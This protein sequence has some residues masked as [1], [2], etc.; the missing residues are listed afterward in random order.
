MRITITVEDPTPEIATFLLALASQPTATVTTEPDDRWTPERA[1]AY[2]NLLPPRARQILRT[3]TDND[4]HCDATSL[5]QGERN[6]RGTTGAFRRILN[7]GARKGL[8][9]D[10]LPVPVL[11]VRYNGAVASFSAAPDTYEVF[12]QALQDGD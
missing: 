6:L 7:E 12:A 11:S 1:R 8:W 3:V 5:R 10:A 4:G 9:P 2:Y